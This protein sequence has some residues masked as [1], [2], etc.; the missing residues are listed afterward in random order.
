MN[1]GPRLTEPLPGPIRGYVTEPSVV[2]D[3]RA[4]WR[5]YVSGCLDDLTRLFRAPV[6]P[7]PLPSPMKGK[8]PLKASSPRLRA[9][10]THHLFGFGRISPMETAL[11]REISR[12]FREI[13]I[14]VF[15]RPELVV[16][17]DIWPADY[18]KMIIRLGRLVLRN[19]GRLEIRG[20]TVI[21]IGELLTDRPHQ[22]S[23]VFQGPSGRDGTPGPAGAAGRAGR[24]GRL[25]ACDCCGGR[26]E[27]TP[28]AGEAGEPG[29]KGGRGAD[30][31]DGLSAYP[32]HL[33]LGSLPH[34][35]LVLNLGGRGGHGGQ[36]GPGG[37]GG[38]VVV[39]A[40][41]G[42]GRLTVKDGEAQPGR[43]GSGGLSPD[44][45]T[46]QG[47]REGRPGRQGTSLVIIR[48]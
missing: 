7:E 2:R 4:G 36:G 9:A 21:E 8:D 14:Y 28:T 38:L 29:Q 13:P 3:L 45:S 11:R 6:L 33:I 27:L 47:G 12:R 1:A 39:S 19:G 18:N 26:V 42:P 17:R 23:I 5:L 41:S 31:S 46:G 24:D 44:G 10:V 34:D 37:R 20:A 35:V 25:A 30:G 48:P 32:G 22:P 15:E 16:D 40:P 43:P